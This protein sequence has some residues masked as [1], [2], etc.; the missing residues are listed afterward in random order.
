MKNQERCGAIP[1]VPSRGRL[2][3]QHSLQ[4]PS[5]QGC[6]RLIGDLLQILGEVLVSS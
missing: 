5:L 4:P 6:E 1:K 2:E 3:L